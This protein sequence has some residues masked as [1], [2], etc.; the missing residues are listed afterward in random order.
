MLNAASPQADQE[1][2]RYNGPVIDAHHHFWD[3]ARNFHPWLSSAENIPFRY[4]DYSAIKRRYYPED[5]FADAAQHHV[6]ETVY[7]ETEWDPD[8]PLGETRFIASLAREYGAPNAVVAQ[9]WLHHDDAAAVIAAQAANRLVR[10]VRHKPG[11]ASTPGDARAVRSLMDDGTW[12]KGYAHLQPHGLHFDLQTP[13]WHLDAAAR[14][15]RDFP[16]TQIILNHAGLPSDR[17]AEGMRAWRAAMALAAAQP[18]IAVKIS[19]I[20]QGGV[21]WTLE[22]NATIIRACIE[23]FTPDRV[24]FASNFPVDSLCVDF[25]TLFSGFKQVAAPYSPMQQQAMFHDNAKRIY[26][27]I[28]PAELKR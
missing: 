20:G 19:G 26:R 10:S 25:D 2:A 18:N 5:Y 12:R 27:T 3:P 24:M 14:L 1:I 16:D 7:V 13:W 9:A 21:A 15:A 17:S 23:L 11:G 8:D 6:V 28:P 22:S 4:G